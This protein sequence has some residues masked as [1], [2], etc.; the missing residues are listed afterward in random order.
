V[1]VPINII[2]GIDSI[3]N[4]FIE[5]R[6]DASTFALQNNVQF[7]LGYK[8]DKYYFKTGINLMQWHEQFNMQW[9]ERFKIFDKIDTVTYTVLQPFQPPLYLTKI[10]SVFYTH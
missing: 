4:I 8:F 10:D 5:R 6:K 2:K 1:A 7:R 9:Y 3:S